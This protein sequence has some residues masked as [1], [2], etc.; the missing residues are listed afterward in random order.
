MNVKRSCDERRVT[1]ISLSGM[2]ESVK[3]PANAAVVLCTGKSLP[4]DPDR[5]VTHPGD[6]GAG[7]SGN[8]NDPIAKCKD[9]EQEQPKQKLYVLPGDHSKQPQFC[10]IF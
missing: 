6:R 1:A 5:A 10:R 2:V 9:D 4:L 7:C 3:N 8:D